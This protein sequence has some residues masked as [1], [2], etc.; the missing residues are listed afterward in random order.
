MTSVGPRVGSTVQCTPGPIDVPTPEVERG[1]V[2]I[3]PLCTA[4]GMQEPDMSIYS[5]VQIMDGID[6]TAH[7]EFFP[8]PLNES[9]AQALDKS[10]WHAL[11]VG[12]G[13][14]AAADLAPGKRPFTVGKPVKMVDINHFHFSTGHLGENLLR[15]T[16]LQHGIIST[17]VLQP[18]A[19][20]VEA[21]GVR[22]GV[23][24]RTTSRAARPMETAH[25]DLAGPYEAS[26]GGSVYLI[27]LVDSAS[28]W[29]RPYG[30]KK[31][32]E[33]TAYV[34]KFIA[35][36]N[37]MGLPRCFRTDNGGEFTGRSYV[38][39]CDSAGIR[40]EHT[41]PGKP[42]QNAVVESAIWRAMKGGHV[43][44]REIQ[45]L[46]P[47]VDLRRIP[48][49]GASGNRLWLEAVLWAADCFN[50]SATKA[51]TCWRS[52]YGVFFSLGCKCAIHGMG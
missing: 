44:R 17:G 52:P 38:D 39:F 19:G 47:D 9:V 5:D 48:N 40:R 35:D 43:A 51:N 2:T 22:A 18:C 29:M 20:C 1:G 33:T 7:T 8:P 15:A 36:M 11:H 50:R 37:H 13:M 46:F 25:I 27:M 42:Q 4:P 26:I 28:R 30:M 10:D 45:R 16:A 49:L 14:T 34:K 41:A 31:K 24:R 6:S 23:P 12:D 3:R 21:K 32:S